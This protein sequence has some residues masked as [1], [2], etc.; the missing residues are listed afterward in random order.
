MPAKLDEWSIKTPQVYDSVAIF[1]IFHLNKYFSGWIG[2]RF[3][4]FYFTQIQHRFFA[5][6]LCEI[7]G[8]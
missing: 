8:K 6:F 7:Y 2:A 4:I 5:D 1:L 3:W